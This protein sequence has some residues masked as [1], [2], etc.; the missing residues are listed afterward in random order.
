LDI[1]F[2]LKF[3]AGHLEPSFE[4]GESHLVQNLGLSP[5]LSFVPFSC[6]LL[7]EVRAAADYD[8]VVALF[9]YSINL[10]ES[11]LHVFKRLVKRLRD[12]STIRVMECHVVMVQREACVLYVSSKIIYRTLKSHH[13]IELLFVAV[14]FLIKSKLEDSLTLAIRSM[15]E[16]EH[17]GSSRVYVL[18]DVTAGSDLE[19]LPIVNYVHEEDSIVLLPSVVHLQLCLLIPVDGVVVTPSAVPLSFVAE[20]LKLNELHFFTAFTFRILFVLELLGSYDGVA[21]TS[22]KACLCH[23]SVF[24]FIGSPNHDCVVL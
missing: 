12:H 3:L 8:S 4:N 15:S 10:L 5:L 20:V 7:R 11:V 6:K 17:G 9:H 14:L 24:F 22:L 18:L 2:A 19:D 23:D 16:V 1:H 21:V 13:G